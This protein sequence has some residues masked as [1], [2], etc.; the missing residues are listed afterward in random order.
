DGGSEKTE[1]F[2]EVDDSSLEK[3]NKLQD[4]FQDMKA[5]LSSN[6]PS[7]LSDELGMDTELVSSEEQA[8]KLPMGTPDK[9]RNAPKVQEPLEVSQSKHPKKSMVIE[10]S[11]SSTKRT[12][13]RRKPKVNPVMVGV[14]LG[15][16]AILFAAYSI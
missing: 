3:N 8:S 10:P 12:S 1:L 15:C 14:V 4:L 5:D 11:K 9:T 2:G 16:G 6:K 13:R 7:S